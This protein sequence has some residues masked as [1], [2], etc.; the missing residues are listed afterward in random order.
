M[1]WLR[2]ANVMNNTTITPLTVII[3][4]LLILKAQWQIWDILEGVSS[5]GV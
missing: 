2:F 4:I 1:K 3:A 5:P